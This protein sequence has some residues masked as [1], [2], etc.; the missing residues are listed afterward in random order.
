M[1]LIFAKYNSIE[2]VAING[3]YSLVPDIQRKL[4]ETKGGEW[5]RVDHLDIGEYIEFNDTAN[6]QGFDIKRD[7]YFNVKSILNKK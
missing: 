5:L 6:Y 4:M 1:V 2:R 3:T 7:R